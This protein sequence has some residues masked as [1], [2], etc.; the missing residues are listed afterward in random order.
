MADNN[1][2]VEIITPDRVFYTGEAEM[3]ELTTVEGDMGI[4]KNHIPLTAVLAPGK[5]TIH[6]DEDLKIAA[7]H[8]G[9]VE[10]LQD[11][12]TLLAEVAEW[13]GEIDLNRA[14]AAKDRAEERL[15]DHLNETDVKRAEYALRKALTRIDVSDYRDDR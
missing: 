11:K 15:K 12:V 8:A 3:I 4:Y 6:Q 1:F 9:F 5:V 2:K 14:Q 7:V 13:P 10:I